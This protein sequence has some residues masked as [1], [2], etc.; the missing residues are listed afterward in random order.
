MRRSDGVQNFIFY[1]AIDI[2]QTTNKKLLLV[3]AFKMINNNKIKNALLILIIM[4]AKCMM[5]GEITSTI[6]Y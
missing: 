5:L 1:C 6:I 2:K 3:L 4:L